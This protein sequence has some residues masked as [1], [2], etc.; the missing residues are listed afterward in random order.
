MGTLEASARCSR[1][2]GNAAVWVPHAAP[3]QKQ[4]RR[5][6]RQSLPQC[7]YCG[8]LNPRLY[9]AGSRRMQSWLS[10]AEREQYFREVRFSEVDCRCGFRECAQAG[11]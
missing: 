7:R 9:I 10:P 11:G 4:P 3:E 8:H 5:R 6:S 2:S 1:P